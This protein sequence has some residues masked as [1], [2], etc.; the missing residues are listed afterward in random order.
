MSTY[1][2]TGWVNN[3]EPAIDE[4]NLNHA[5]IGVEDAHDEIEDIAIGT[6]S[7]ALANEANKVRFIPAATKNIIGGI[8]IEN[9]TDAVSGE[10]TSIIT[11]PAVTEPP[12][13]IIDLKASDNLPGVIK[14]TFT[15]GD[16][17][18]YDLY[19]DEEMVAT[20]IKTGFFYR[21][22][23]GT[24]DFHLVSNNIFGGTR[25]IIDSGTAR[26]IPTEPPAEITDFTASDKK[27]L[28][29]IVAWR[30][31]GDA[32]KF[33]LFQDMVMVAEDI[34]PGY[35]FITPE[36]THIYHVQAH[37]F[38]GSTDSNEDSGT[39]VGLMPDAPQ[40]FIASDD[41]IANVN[42]LFDYIIQPATYDLYRDGALAVSN[43][44][45]D[46]DFA[47]L[48]S[49][50]D[51]FVRSN[52]QLGTADSEINAGTALPALYPPGTVIDFAASDEGRRSL[53]FNFSH[54]IDAGRY[55]LFRNEALYLSD[56]YP[57]MEIDSDAG[58]WEFR[59]DAINSK[60]TAQSN[61]DSGTALPAFTSAP[62]AIADFTASDTLVNS[63]QIQYTRA[64]Q[65][66][67][68]D[69]FRGGVAYKTDIKPGDVFQCFGGTWSFHIMAVNPLGTQNSNADDGTAL[70]ANTA[71]PP[72]VDFLASDAEIAKVIVTFSPAAGAARYDLY[73]DNLPVMEDIDSGYSYLTEPGTWSFHVVA[74]NLKGYSA[75][76]TDPGTAAVPD[77]PPSLIGDFDATDGLTEQIIMTFTNAEGA[78][79]HDLWRDD[80]LLIPNIQNGYS[81]SE[82]GSWTFKVVA[83]NSIGD[84]PS[85]VNDGSSIASIEPPSY[86]G[87]LLASDNEI[88]QVT[89]TWNGV[90]D[91]DYYDLYVN[92]SLLQGHAASGFVHTVSPGTRTYQHR[93]V[94]AS[95]VDTP[96]NS[97]TGT[98]IAEVEPPI[99]IS[100]FAATT[101]YMDEITC[102]WSNVPNV[103]YYDLYDGNG[104]VYS[105]TSSGAVVRPGPGHSDSYYVKAV[106]AEGASNSNSALGSTWDHGELELSTTI[107]NN[108]VCGVDFPANVSIAYC[109]IG[110]GGSGASSASEVLEFDW[111][112]AGGGHAGDVST[113]VFSASCGSSVLIALGIGAPGVSA[114]MNTG[115]DGGTGGDTYVDGSWIFGGAGGLKG[116]NGPY[117]SFYQG[118][119]EYKNTCGETSQDGTLGYVPSDSY[120]WWGYGGEASFGDGGNGEVVNGSGSVTSGGIGAGGGGC[121]SATGYSAPSGAGGNGYVKLTW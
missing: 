117:D 18:Y 85:N 7:V 55:D 109:A 20:N 6:T 104:V 111:A 63:V 96:S 112:S 10:V 76:N 15:P 121:V 74:L 118:E 13:A 14:I 79:Q 59:V 56:V 87:S 5:E 30:D 68:H 42:M 31:H 103:D 69:L 34:R 9:I 94:N 108:L 58:T 23:A 51:Y 32:A 114:P 40:N 102:T 11:A 35:Q 26:A 83:I 16:A 8:K 120:D 97:N 115:I 90:G 113:S 80:A 33:D 44:N 106:N 64:D 100:N 82:V 65:A 54:A 73:R 47:V 28:K 67:R 43:I 4:S 12:T 22:D 46:Y 36:S 92:G 91:A 71:P 50:N 78:T 1:K 99:A 2:P 27:A 29:V 41:E 17:L 61:T 116:V 101:C 72:I 49:T 37:N 57:G 75:S 93:A 70:A 48:D 77:L 98:S 53:T 39:A 3:T 24:W 38:L 119:G 21:T 95:G 62:S 60:G 88:G 84:T 105:D 45:S 66:V 89:V 81:L 19:R 25:S 110:G 107:I 52:N 86:D